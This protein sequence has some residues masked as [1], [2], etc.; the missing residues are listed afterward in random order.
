MNKQF[1][2]FIKKILLF[3]IPIWLLILVY[4]VAD[5]FH[6]IYSYDNYG[7]NYLKTFNR[8]RLSTE[9]FLRYNPQYHFSSFIFGSS[10]SSAF[11][12]YDWAEIINDPN[13]FHFDA[14]NDNI[15]GIK[16]K[17]EFIKNQGNP[18]KNALLVFDNDTFS[19][20]FEESGSIVHQK[21][22]RWTGENFFVYHLEFFKAFFKKQ[23]FISFIDLKLF[24][25]YRP[26]MDEFF[27][28]KYYYKAPY[29]DFYFPENEEKIKQDSLNYYKDPEF[30]SRKPEKN[31]YESRIQEHH[32][33]DIKTVSDLLKKEKTDYK[34]I[35]SPLFNQR[36][37]HPA[38]LEI[39]N[40]YFGKDRIY[41]YSGKNKITDDIR[42]YYEISHFKP[43]AGKIILKEIYQKSEKAN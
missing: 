19:E 12:T 28:F 14:F 4:F 38:D 21:D 31:T 6:V 36:L 20:E 32:L 35:I 24:K 43:S 37:W 26:Y 13:P 25:T 40:F 5:P 33:N 2:L 41:N 10:R 42:Y 9:T 8:N 27:K 34:V 18:I 16:G 23:Y 39:L 22:Y 15:S 11:R 1:R 29:N 30:Y 3:G 17:I 7:S